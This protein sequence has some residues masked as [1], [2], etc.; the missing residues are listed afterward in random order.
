MENIPLGKVIQQKIREDKRTAKSISGELGMT[1]TNLSK[2]YSKTSLNTELLAKLSIVLEYDFFVH[3]NPYIMEGTDFDTKMGIPLEIVEK[4]RSHY[5]RLQTCFSALKDSQ[6]ALEAV[7]KEVELLRTT[8]ASKDR[9]EGL[10]QKEIDRLTKQ[11][12]DLLH[13]Q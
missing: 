8:V 7:N 6:R 13:P 3:V 5:A 9:V 2:I 10:L 1:P 12:H 4:A 11:V